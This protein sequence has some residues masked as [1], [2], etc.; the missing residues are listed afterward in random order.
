MISNIDR[1]GRLIRAITGVFCLILGVVVVSYGWNESP[2]FRW[3]VG[4]ILVLAG[5]FQ[6]F[7]AQKGWCVMR[8]L[9]FRTPI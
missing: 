8:A 2:T 6:L 5:L 3:T 1:K 4:G 9:G 7:E